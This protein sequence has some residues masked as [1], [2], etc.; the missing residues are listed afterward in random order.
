VPNGTLGGVRGSDD[1]YSI[2][3]GSRSAGASWS[4]GNLPHRFPDWSPAGS[5]G[6][7]ILEKVTGVMELNLPAASGDSLCSTVNPKSW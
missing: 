6:I 4:A 7:G 2:V 1:T 3:C 5:A